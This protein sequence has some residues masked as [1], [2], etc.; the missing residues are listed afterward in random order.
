MKRVGWWEERLKLSHF[1]EKY[2]AKAFPV[3]PTFFLGEI[4]LFSF[5]LLVITGIYLALFY[6][7][8]VRIVTVGGQSM[9][10]AYGSVTQIDQQPFG[11]IVR[12]VHH[13]SA[14]L[15]VAAVILHLL[16]IFF[17]GAF[18]KPREINWLVGCVLLLLTVGAA[19][20]GYLLPYDEFSVTAT[21]IGY[22]MA[23]SAP[24]V[25]KAVADF[26][27]AG[28]FPALGVIPR[29]YSYHVFWV[30]LLL[31][32]LI[33]A[34]LIVMIKQKHTEP[35]YNRG[36]APSGQLLGI[37]LWPQQATLMTVLFLLMTG[38][39]LLLAS[40]FPVHPVEAY[41]PPGP[42]TPL[43]R[44]DWYLLW[45]YGLLKLIPGWME[46]RLWGGVIN[47]E[48]IGGVLLPGLIII[49]MFLLPFLDRAKEPQHYLEPLTLRPVRTAVGMGTAALLLTLSAVG[50]QDALGISVEDS[51]LA[52]LLIPISVGLLTYGIAR[53]FQSST[54]KPSER[55][56]KPSGARPL[57]AQLR[58]RSGER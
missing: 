38:G 8:S 20:S 23:A 35:S 47:P 52:A 36:K 26:V 56:Q 41:G 43:V 37:P 15:M 27:F 32:G 33:G 1:K 58:E 6:E 17:T 54:E 42:Q 10:A 13:W 5:V 28:K 25:G 12:Q 51:R 50:Y 19:F 30:P 14:H 18:R 2:L 16:R 44:P 9:P 24:W 4:A 31:I 45:V 7:P 34:H 11:L 55:L 48:A 40:T 49:F 22:Q 21:G 57:E 29:F 39:V 3:H 53:R 46:V